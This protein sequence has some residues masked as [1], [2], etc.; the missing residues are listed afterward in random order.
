MHNDIIIQ[1]NEKIINN[2]SEFSKE[3]KTSKTLNR[4]P[5]IWINRGGILMGLVL[6]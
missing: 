6:K 3:L 5:I 2:I 4:K 1:V